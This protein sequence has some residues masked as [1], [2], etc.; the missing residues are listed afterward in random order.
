M[1]SRIGETNYNCI[2]GFGFTINAD[3]IFAVGIKDGNRFRPITPNDIS[4]LNPIEII[5]FMRMFEN[6]RLN[7][8]EI[9]NLLNE[10][11]DNK[12]KAITIVNLDELY[13]N[14]IPL[15][16]ERDTIKLISRKIAEFIS[17]KT[18]G[19]KN[20]IRLAIEKRWIY[21]TLRKDICDPYLFNEL[22]VLNRI[23]AQR[24]IEGSPLRE[25]YNQAKQRTLLTQTFA[26]TA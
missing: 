5:S 23:E 26:L 22:Q 14:S 6:M 15:L 9:Y 11:Y 18:Y 12:L 2:F 8:N 7:T 10:L 1:I 3:K 19:Y 13:I 17:K 16:D 24:L 20:P 25:L 4:G 21:P